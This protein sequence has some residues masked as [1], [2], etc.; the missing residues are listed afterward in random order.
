[1]R[2]TIRYETRFTILKHIHIH[3]VVEKLEVLLDIR[4]FSFS[5]ASILERKGGLCTIAYAAVSTQE[6][7]GSS[8]DPEL[9][10]TAV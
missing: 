5:F 8:G 1:M 3:H 4:L 9:H 6:Q 2:H 10:C 7:K